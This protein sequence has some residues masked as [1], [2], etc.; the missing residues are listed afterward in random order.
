MQIIEQGGYTRQQIIDMLHAKHSSRMIKFRYDLLNRQEIKIGTLDNV[1][2]GEVSMAS[3][4]TD[5]KRTARFFMKDNKGIDWLNDRIQPFCMLRMPDG[6]WV[7]WSLGIFLLNSPKRQEQNTKVYRDVEAYDGLQVLLD[8]KFDSRYTIAA[9]TKYITAIQNIFFTLGITK[10]NIPNTDLTLPIAK[11]FEIGTPK[12]RAINELLGELNYTSLWV[13]ERGYYTAMPY[14][15]PSDRAIDYHYK[16]DELSIIHPGLEEELDLFNVP[17]KWVVVQSNAETE[18]LVSI[19]TNENPASITST[20]SRGR[21]IV[22]FRQV[23]NIADQTALNNYTKRL[24]FEASQIYGHI[25]F[26]TAIMP[27]HSY[28]DLLQ[29]QYSKLE[30]NDRYVETNWTIPLKAG[31]KMSHKARRVVA[32]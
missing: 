10:I 11:E 8:D 6:G 27:M 30:I 2:S 9:G 23:D 12:L 15:I 3:L 4:A 28:S 13:D 26:E 21:T 24:A 20:V 5:I 7:E 16:D 29:I 22:D 32:I 31:A 19:Y 14:V 17:N 18:P 1:V 25:E